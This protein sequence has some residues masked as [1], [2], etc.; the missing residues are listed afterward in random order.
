M[1][2]IKHKKVKG[3]VK[4]LSATLYRGHK[5]IVRMI[6]TD[7]FE[8]ITEYNGEI[9]SSYIIITPSENKKRLTKKQIA[10][11]AAL[12]YSGAEATLDVLTGSELGEETKKIVTAFESAREIVE[13][14]IKD[15]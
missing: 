3:R 4:V 10:E 8:Y 9:Y 7:Y 11:C 2:N 5:V 15:D 13:G 12:I 1:E 14:E 6:G